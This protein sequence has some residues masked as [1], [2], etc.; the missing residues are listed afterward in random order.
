MPPDS[1]PAYPPAVETDGAAARRYHD[2][3]GSVLP[4][5]DLAAS[6]TPPKHHPGTP[7]IRLPFPPFGGSADR[8]GGLLA[9]LYGVTRIDWKASGVGAGRPVPSGGGAY[10][11]EVYAATGSGLCHYLPAAHALELLTPADLRADLSAC[12]RTPATEQ[13]DLPEPPD[14][15]E[16]PDQRDQADQPELILLITS[17]HD[18]N[19]ARYGPFGHRLQA[20][21]TGVLAGQ[22]LTLLAAAGGRPAAHTLFAD[23]PLSRLLGLDPGAESVHVVVTSGPLTGP[24]PTG[25]L[26]NRRSAGSGFEP[27]PIASAQLA[28]VLDQV[29]E[30][31]PLNGPN[32]PG[33]DLYCVAG[34]VAGLAPGCHRRDP[35]SGELLPVDGDFS[36]RAVPRDLFPPGGPGELA[37]FEAACAV[38]VVGDYERGYADHGDRWYRMLNIRAGILGQRI[39]LA[40]ARAGLGAGLRCDVVG[41]RTDRVLGVSPGR[42]ALL[43][44]LIGPERGSGAPSQQLVRTGLTGL[45]EAN[46]LDRLAGGR[47]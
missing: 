1:G 36:A 12:L 40:A 16:H 47:P 10:P 38:L 8:L 33:I 26:L 5:I 28:G 44:A 14:R 20:L 41:S 30:P 45:T 27:V 19:L 18:A 32:A 42:T 17:R 29:A 13:P 7:L 23:R 6:N 21:D 11:G 37:G 2:R 39:G 31:V 3:Y 9:L 34:R 46:G 43:T 25:A 22:A 24:E 35:R 4:V 15:P